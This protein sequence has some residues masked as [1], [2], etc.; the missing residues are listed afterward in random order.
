[1]TMAGESVQPR[2]QSFTGRVAAILA[3]ELVNK[4]G[5][6]VA[7]ILLAHTID[8]T[9]YGDV[10]W[11][12]SATMVFALAS[13]A[14]LS[15]W[16]SAQIAVRP[17]DAALIAGRVAALRFTMAVP[18]YAVLACL[19]WFRGGQA[20]TALLVYGLM[21]FV[22]PLF[23]QYLFNGF[24][25]TR[26][27]A[28]G[29]ALRGLTFAAAVVL[30]VQPAS[31]PVVV[32]FAEVA[33]A[34]A[35]ALCNAI[36][37]LR[38]FPSVARRFPAAWWD[39][40][41]PANLRAVLGRSWRIGASEI[42]WAVLWYSGLVL[43]G[44]LATSADAAWHSAGLRL[45]LA[46]HTG[47]WLYLFV[48]L[49]NLTRLLASDHAA[50]RR[51]TEE[52]LRLTAWMGLAAALACTLGARPILTTI[53]GERFEPAIPILR[54][55]I[56]VVPIAW[57]SGHLRYSFI[58]ADRPEKDY[59][60]ALVGAS[61]TVAATLVLVPAWQSLGAAAALLIGMTA[62]AVAAGVLAR[63]LLP[64]VSVLRS[65]RAGTIACAVCLAVG[66]GLAPLLGEAAATAAAVS[67]FLAAALVAERDRARALWRW[68]MG[69]I[70]RG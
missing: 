34:L 40:F 13:D 14:G 65:V 56:W 17:A 52:S 11:A 8:P 37:L 43:L 33:A 68:Q 31:R 29:N 25:Q 53:F 57:M 32:A 51:L 39:G 61:T 6:V 15:T 69:S 12:L 18:A 9:A 48:L 4:G 3:G 58:A 16:G 35:L 19:A 67:L 62:N 50:W 47:V 23:L 21:L 5:V 1:M 20:G 26:W 59:H 27:A 10:E 30:A 22:T 44:Y 66:L 70:P 7:F 41:R 64:E 2:A 42:S 28:L 45:V 63:G 60:A 49:P 38:V 24:L 55:L 36:V 54:T 46:I